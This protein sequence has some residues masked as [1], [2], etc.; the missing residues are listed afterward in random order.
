MN[1]SMFY[2][3]E[4]IVE[5]EKNH[6]FNELLQ[7]LQQLYGN[8][9]MPQY[10]STIIAYSWYLLI[11]HEYDNEKWYD[12]R[13]YEELWLRYLHI[14]IVDCV[15]DARF[16]FIAGYSLGL[17]FDYVAQYCKDSKAYLLFMQNAAKQNVN[18]YV[19]LLA[20][21]FIS[22]E[23]T[24]KYMPLNNDFVVNELFPTSS[25]LDSYFK[26]IYLSKY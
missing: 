15:D 14:G 11:G 6:Q 25:V 5:C 10:L 9:H 20:E 7:Y 19:K 17:H 12:W 26:E 18:F 16:N 3:D 22:N 23:T 4:I 13:K 8:F 2:S 24:H 1:A 21:N